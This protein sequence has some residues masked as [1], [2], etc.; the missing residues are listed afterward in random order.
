MKGGPRAILER[1]KSE[2]FAFHID[3]AAHLA[4]LPDRFHVIMVSAGITRDEIPEFPYA[5]AR[6]VQE[7]LDMAGA[8][9]GKDARIVVVPSAASTIPQLRP[10]GGKTGG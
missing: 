8:K 6:D 1:A 3:K 7:A 10:A 5:Y 2:A 4:S 9:V